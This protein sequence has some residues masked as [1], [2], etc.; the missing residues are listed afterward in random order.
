MPAC[1]A[2]K[3]AAKCGA[4]SLISLNEC[5]LRHWG[6]RFWRHTP[7]AMVTPP[8]DSTP[9]LAHMQGKTKH[10][11]S[12]TCSFIHT[13]ILGIIWPEWK[14]LECSVNTQHK[15]HTFLC[16]ISYIRWKGFM[17]SQASM[18]AFTCISKSAHYKYQPTKCVWIKLKKIW[19]EYNWANG[20]ILYQTSLIL[21]GFM[22]IGI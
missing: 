4:L 13:I 21:L 2:E 10:R 6:S 19:V 8:W 12:R 18:S 3:K 22:D 1:V 9:L 14:L 16:A 15:S 17:C 11:R 20:Q 5:P 7:S